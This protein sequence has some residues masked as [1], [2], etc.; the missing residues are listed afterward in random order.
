MSTIVKGEAAP[1]DA[2]F[3]V[4]ARDEDDAPTEDQVFDV[5]A[6]RRRRFALH[7]LCRAGDTVDIGTLAERIAAWENRIDPASVTSTERKRVYTALQQSHLPRMH[8]A[9]MVVFDKRAGTVDVTDAA[10]EIDVYLDV[11]RGREIPWSAY[12]AGLSGLGGAILL[13][14]WVGAPPIAWFSPAAWL[15]FVVCAF[16]ASSVAHL[17][18]TRGQR[19]GA[20]DRPAELD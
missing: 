16:A 13:A 6:N 4:D 5:L 11:V 19:L 2:S 1:V 7:A 3:G 9:G 10:A 15:M 12:Y 17:Y 14:L 8:E 18:V 20:A